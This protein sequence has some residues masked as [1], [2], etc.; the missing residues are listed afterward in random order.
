MNYSVVKRRAYRHSEKSLTVFLYQSRS[1]P[2]VEISGDKPFSK[3]YSPLTA[4]VGRSRGNGS[5]PRVRNVPRK[6]RSRGTCMFSKQDSVQ[7]S[8]VRFCHNGTSKATSNVQTLHDTSSTGSLQRFRVKDLSYLRAKHVRDL[9]F[10][11]AL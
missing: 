7:P 3:E 11:A 6:N 2:A 5:R 8:S 4:I 9:F 10:V 1:K